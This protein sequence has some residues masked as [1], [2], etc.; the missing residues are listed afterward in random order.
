MMTL[1]AIARK[2]TA[3]HENGIFQK[4]IADGNTQLFILLL[5]LFV[6]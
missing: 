1:I 5:C 4:E 3:I 2:R 6:A